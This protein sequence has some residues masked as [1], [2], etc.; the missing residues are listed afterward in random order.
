MKDGDARNFTGDSSAV[1]HCSTA[2]HFAMSAIFLCRMEIQNPEFFFGVR[3]L[4]FLFLPLSFDK[5]VGNFPEEQPSH[6]FLH[7]RDFQRAKVAK[8]KGKKLEKFLP[9]F[10]LTPLLLSLY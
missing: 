1:T 7:S 2:I 5:V 8:K 3:F 10:W 4:T 9:I 6:P